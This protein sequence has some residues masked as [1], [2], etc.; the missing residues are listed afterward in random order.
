L[1]SRTEFVVSSGGALAEQV[2]PPV[3][4]VPAAL[5]PPVPGFVEPPAPA[6]V[7][8]AVPVPDFELLQ[9][10]AINVARTNASDRLLVIVHLPLATV[11]A[12]DS[13]RRS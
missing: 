9:L 10:Q 12:V 11:S 4:V 2:V 8:P 5:V 1:R 13:R 6:P 7:V 3:P